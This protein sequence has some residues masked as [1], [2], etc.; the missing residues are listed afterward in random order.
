M[1]SVTESL[2]QLE[3]ELAI[4]RVAQYPDTNYIN[5]LLLCCSS[6]A[7]AWH[8]VAANHESRFRNCI[9]HS[10]FMSPSIPLPVPTIHLSLHPASHDPITT[11]VPQNSESEVK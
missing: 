5:G 11:N 9:A 8:F 3:L 7:A 4:W 1:G 10:D 6:E 2:G